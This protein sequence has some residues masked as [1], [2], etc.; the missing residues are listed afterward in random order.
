MSSDSWDMDVEDES[1]SDDEIAVPVRRRNSFSIISQG[2]I[3]Q[4]I[5]K[6]IKDYSELLG[7]SYDETLLVMT[8]YKWK[9]HKLQDDWIDNELKVRVDSGISPSTEG[10]DYA[11]SRGIKVGSVKLVSGTER[12]CQICLADSTERDALQCQHTFCKECWREYF[13]EAVTSSTAHSA[14]G[15]PLYSCSLKVPESMVLK[16]LDPS[17]IPIYNKNK[18]E[19]FVHMSHGYKWCPSPN[20]QFIAEFPNL[21]AHEI[22]C[23]CGCYFCFSCGCEAHRP[24]NCQ[25]VREWMVK[26]S[27]ESENVTWILAN[28]KQCPSCKKPIEKNQGCNHMTCRVEVGG[29]KYEFCWM[30][31]GPW[32]EHNT[33][34]GGYYRCNKYEEDVAQDNSNTRAEERQREEAKHELD[35]YM[36]YFERYNNHNRAQGL[37]ARQVPDIEAKMQLLHDMKNY[38]IGE[39]EFLKDAAEQVVINRRVLKWTYAFG[40]YLES[41]QEK[42]LFEHLQEK[43]EENTEHL[44]E[45]VEKPLDPYL[46]APAADRVPFYNFKSELVNYYQVTK[47]VRAKQFLNN[48]L[49]GIENGLTA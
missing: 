3:A 18:C 47:R 21:G 19:S 17:L 8:Q 31:L 7:L 10:F 48:L 20:C 40:Y 41:G 14:L 49:D 34:T 22:K 39:L 15:C 9:A 6:Q 38:S 12:C 11:L 26:N 46:K 25:I 37:A 32:S 29:C 35:R 45:M 24:A 44:H 5:E 28:T 2:Q 27:A 43:L 1:S 23:N 13:K 42:N 36:F 16:Y 30:C 33:A 4:K